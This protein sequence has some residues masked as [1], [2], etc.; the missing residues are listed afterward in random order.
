M[1]IT[2][3][4]VEKKLWW[5]LADPYEPINEELYLRTDDGTDAA[6]FE[7]WYRTLSAADRGIVHEVVLEWL[8]SDDR[9]KSSRALWFVGSVDP[10]QVFLP[11]IEHLAG[12]FDKELG[13]RAQVNLMFLRFLEAVDGLNAVSVIPYLRRWAEHFDGPTSGWAWTG[14]RVLRGRLRGGQTR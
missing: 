9:K 6:G 8:S 4:I 11:S 12:Q 10:A 7:K 13:P 1:P 5:P 3:D 2:R 14:L